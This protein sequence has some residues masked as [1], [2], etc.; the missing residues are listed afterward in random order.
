MNPIFI[1]GTERSGTNL[2]RLILNEHNAI[3]VP[4]PPHIMKL[5]APLE[6]LYGD[7]TVDRNFRRL[8]EDVCRMVELH[9]YPWEIRPDREQLFQGVRDRNL[10]CVYFGIYDQ[11][12]AYAGKQR[13]CCK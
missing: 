10:L 12:L 3:A 11:Y 13:W 8:I 6:S 1:I 7:L 2:L 9:P 4:H 5:F